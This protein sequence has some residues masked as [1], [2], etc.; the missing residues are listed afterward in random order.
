[1]RII[2]KFLKEEIG[3]EKIL[4]ALRNMKKTHPQFKHLMAEV[5]IEDGH[6]PK[7]SVKDDN[8][9]VVAECNFEIRKGDV[10]FFKLKGEKKL[11]MDDELENMLCFRFLETI[12]EKAFLSTG[13]AEMF[14]DLSS[15]YLNKKDNVYLI[16]TDYE[17]LIETEKY[18][19]PLE[20]RKKNEKVTQQND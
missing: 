17:T 9:K 20:I 5:S 19:L 18:R 13:G 3:E 11:E 2:V 12:D 10:V 14:Y 6:L 15:F 16:H 4:H 7:Y 8:G 1:M